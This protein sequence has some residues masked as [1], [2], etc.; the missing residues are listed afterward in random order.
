MVDKDKLLSIRNVCQQNGATLVAV[1]KTKPISDIQKAYDAGQRDFG[2]NKAQELQAKQSALPDDIRWHMIGHLQRNKV[3]YIAPFV[4]MIHS[5]DSLRLLKEINK[6]AKQA[7]R[8]INILFQIHIAKE[9]TKYG[10]DA[11]ELNEL[12]DSDTY[13]QMAHITVCGLMGMATFTENKDQVR[14]EF[15]Y[16]KQLF[17]QTRQRHFAHSSSFNTLSMGMSGD[18]DIALSEGSTMIRVGSLIFGPRETH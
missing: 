9:D 14:S 16:L 11:Q 2:E 10:L 6:R 4:Y 1:S 3:K 15:Q 18:F 7:N 8:S 5:V 12:L 13:R 17:D